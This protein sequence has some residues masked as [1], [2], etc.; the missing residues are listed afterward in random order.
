MFDRFL[1]APILT[2]LVTISIPMKHDHYTAKKCFQLRIS[3][4]SQFFE[5]SVTFT[6]KII[7]QKSHSVQRKL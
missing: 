4:G 7:Y 3:C 1:N 5:D 6:G 2:T